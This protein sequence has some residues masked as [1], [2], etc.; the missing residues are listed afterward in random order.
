MSLRLAARSTSKR[1]RDAGAAARRTRRFTRRAGA[2]CSSRETHK[3]PGVKAK[4]AP[5][6]F[7]GVL[8]HDNSDGAP[9]ALLVPHRQCTTCFAIPAHRINCATTAPAC[10]CPIVF[11]MLGRGQPMPTEL[12]PLDALHLAPPCSGGT[13][14]APISS[15]RR[16]TRRWGWRHARTAVQSLEFRAER[17]V[18]L[19][20]ERRGY[21]RP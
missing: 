19:C 5:V 1:R 10:Q 11:A 6:D 3:H 8:E 17:S 14:R 2:C 21:G 9:A 18:M 13:C 16:T 4:A 20:A 7:A 12:G 15:W